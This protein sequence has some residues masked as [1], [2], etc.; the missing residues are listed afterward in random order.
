MSVFKVKDFEEYLEGLRNIFDMV[1][2]VN[3]NTNK[4]M[5][6]VDTDNTLHGTDCYSLWEKGNA[7]KNCI[8]KKALKRQETVTKFE[9]NKD[10]IYL[11][12]ATPIEFEGNIQIV[13]L[14]KCIDD[15]DVI[16]KLNGVH[17]DETSKV[18]SDL[19]DKVR[20]DDLTGV[21][22]RRYINNILPKEIEMS[23]SKEEQSTIIM[24]DVDNFKQINDRYGYVAGDLV[25]QE[26]AHTMICHIRKDYDWVAR[27]GGDEFLIFLRNT[28]KEI[29]NKVINNLRSTLDE[30]YFSF[31]NAKI[32][33]SI[34]AGVAILYEDDKSMKDII[35]EADKNLKRDKKH[36]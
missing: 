5:N 4:T 18:I 9:Y 6:L 29:A 32:K 24:I 35:N 16:F 25:L 17:I 2:L 13:E 3:P 1:R 36:Q 22:N 11:V 33:V 26:L 20:R 8:S 21:Y 19:S 14:L 15:P 12:I 31:K 27:Y 28:D 30:K 34:S 7:C 10:D 23:R